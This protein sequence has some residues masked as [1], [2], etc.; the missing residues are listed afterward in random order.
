MPA[1]AFAAPCGALAADNP[2]IARVEVFPVVYPVTGHFKFLK[3]GRPAAFVKITCDGGA[4]GWGQSVPLPSWSYETLESVVSTIERYLAPALIGRDPFDIA[5]AHAAMDRAIAPSF[6]TGMPIA[7]AGI[8]LALHD[9]CGRIRG[10]GIAELW[11][12]NPLERIRLSWT[13][14]TASLDEVEKLVAQGRERGYG[15]FNTKVAPDAAFDV[16]LCR[17]VRALAPEAFLWADANGGYEP[18]AAFDALPR[19]ERAGVD[20]IE[21]PVA[22]NRLSVFHALKNMNVMPVLMDEGVVAASDLDEFIALG[23]LDGVAIKPARTGGLW[24][25]RKQVE[26]LERRRLMFLGS[27]LT[28]P[29]VALAAAVQLYAAY[30]LKYPA[31]LNGPQFLEGTFLRKPIEVR[32][33]EAVVPAG[34]GLGVEVDEE[35]VR[36]AARKAAAA[37]GLARFTFHEEGG[38]LYVRELGRPVL[39]Y[40]FGMQLPQG[41]PGK[42]RRST[43]IHPVWAPNGAMVTDDFPKDHPHHHGIAWMWPRVQVNGEMHSTWEPD[44]RTRQEF[45]RWIAREADRHSARIEV[46]NAWKLDGRDFMREFVTI[47]I[48]PGN[49]F[50]VALSLD[51]MDE[52]VAIGGTLTEKKGYGGFGFRFGPRRNTVMRTD[53]GESG[54]SLMQRHPWAEFE[55]DYEGGHARVRIEDHPSNPGYPNPWMLRG[56]GYLNVNYPGLDMRIIE[57]GKPLHL[58]YRVTVES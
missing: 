53:R 49:R 46:E 19:L 56:Y 1:L 42:Y 57:P 50:R 31:A 38:R 20:V 16:E 58:E 23:A 11:G 4:F 54:D 3:D 15:H 43:Y 40:T 30:G 27:G 10:Q 45:V 51:A 28:D 44:G 36:S 26:T 41:V 25:A 35:R 8:D 12:R 6:S 37:P 18:A 52:P 48:E 9:L 21:Q 13:V 33:G 34:P 24:E 14:N 47:A 55:A 5:G 7:K 29:D 22:A 39:A 2:A 17:R 32:G